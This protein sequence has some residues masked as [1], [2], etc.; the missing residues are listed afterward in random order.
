MDFEKYFKDF[1][2]RFKRSREMKT[3][4]LITGEWMVRGSQKN[5]IAFVEFILKDPTVKVFEF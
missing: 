1:N 4:D 2:L 5:H 3:N